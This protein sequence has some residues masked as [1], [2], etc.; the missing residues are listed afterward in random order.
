M[1]GCVHAPGGWI[2]LE[3]CVLIVLRVRVSESAVSVNLLALL[4]LMAFID[5]MQ[6]TVRAMRFD[7]SSG[8]APLTWESDRD[9]RFA[10][11]RRRGVGKEANL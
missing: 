9:R 1:R 11:P 10:V 4:F 8:A 5:A 3:G 2:Y 7:E 6:T